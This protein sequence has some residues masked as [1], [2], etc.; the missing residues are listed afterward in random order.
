LWA[1][2]VMLALDLQ[3][4]LNQAADHLRAG[5]LAEAEVLFRQVLAQKPKHAD[6]L[7]L[8]GVTASKASR[9]TE[10]VELIRRAIAVD[11]RQSVFHN[12]LGLG[13]LTVGQI[14]EAIAEFRAAI[15]LRPDS[16]DTYNHLGNALCELGRFDEAL[17]HFH[18]AASAR[19]EHAPYHY[20]L[21]N[22]WRRKGMAMRL[23]ANPS[24]L[25]AAMTERRRVLQK[26]VACFRQALALDP[27]YSDAANNLGTTLQ[28]M[29][30]SDEAIAVW[31]RSLATKPDFFAFYNLG[32]ALYEQDRMDEAQAA[33]QSG[34]RLRPDHAESF[35]NLGNVF[36][37]TGRAQEAIECFDRATAL[38]AAGSVAQSNRLYTLYY[39]PDHDAQRILLEHRKW[40]DQLARPLQSN[41]GHPNDRSPGRRLRIGYVSPNFWGHCQALFTVPLFSR[42]D[43]QQFEI[44]CYSDVKSPDSFTG[45]LR[46]W[47][48]VWR[49]T[50]AM[51]DEQ[52]AEL[53]RRD[54]I[55]ILVDLTLHM[56]ENRM[57][58]FARKPAPMQV[59]WLGYPGTTGLQTMDYR[60]TDPYLDPPGET[61]AL[62]TEKSIR[63]P[64]TFWCMDPEAT[65]MSEMPGINPLPALQAGHVTFGC[66]NN[67]CKVNQ[68]LLEL[69]SRVLDAV[70]GSRMVLLAP[71]GSRRQWISHTLGDR[72]D[73]VSR[74]SR[75]NY[76][77]FYNRID[78]GLDTLPYNGHTTSID[79]LW[80]GVPVVTLIGKTVVGRAGFSQLSN[81]GLTEL[82]ATT[83]E[84]FVELA[85]KVAADLSRLAELRR[86]LR[87]R[88]RSSPLM[89]AERF[90]RDIESAY[91]QMWLTWCR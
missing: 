15:S 11:P 84:Q 40:N 78:L 60:L 19:P 27:D 44:Y 42:H 32:R 74:E 17:P 89:D 85:A 61:D 53:I 70:P 4:K 36:R 12:N 71:P 9:S 10:A 68:P 83:P 48:D 8:L 86:T 87:D 56:A 33:M 64:H 88:T 41:A 67:F 20:N 35:T 16:L 50:V 28:A 34:L 3:R 45:R 26:A 43:H 14:E 1:T 2:K 66:F 31:Q 18:H 37:Q 57:L 22:C 62:Y 29:G 90:A 65:E 69:W 24:N 72:V 91:R 55:D 59:T 63:L 46:A 81:V 76:L 21:A 75:Q 30:R 80:M 49:S 47:A 79:S 82:A 13:L 77:Q 5:R 38:N 7:H 39:H 58:L 54:Q 51:S 73:F 6:A 23:D 52:V 25:Q